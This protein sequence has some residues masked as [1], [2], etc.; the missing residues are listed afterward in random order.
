MS[1][2]HPSR[3]TISKRHRYTW[4]KGEGRSNFQPKREIK[5]IFKKK[6]CFCLGLTILSSLCDHLK[7]LL[8]KAFNED[9]GLWLC[10]TT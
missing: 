7:L 5:H 2:P 9:F 6:S 3:L 8:K 10:V 4:V 1:L